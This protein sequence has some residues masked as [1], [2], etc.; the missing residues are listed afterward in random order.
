MA[1]ICYCSLAAYVFTVGVAS[2]KTR[3][4]F[5]DALVSCLLNFRPLLQ[6][7][8]ACCMTAGQAPYSGDTTPW[9]K[10]SWCAILAASTV[11]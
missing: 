6:L 1:T 4:Y 3:D 11:D 9:S 7:E 10:L 8:L 5:M 2:N